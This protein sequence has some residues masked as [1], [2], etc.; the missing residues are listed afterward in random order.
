[1]GGSTSGLTIGSHEQKSETTVGKGSPNPDRMD[2]DDIEH[3]T[4]E[5]LE[6]MS[7]NFSDAGSDSE[8]DIEEEFSASNEKLKND[9][10]DSVH[11]YFKA[12]SNRVKTF[13]QLILEDIDDLET[14]C[15]EM[16]SPSQHADL[17]NV[18]GS[19]SDEDPLKLKERI[20]SEI[21]EELD[22]PCE[23]H[24]LNGDYDT[25]YETHKDSERQLMFEWRRLEERLRQEEEQRLAEL[26]AEREQSLKSDSEEKEK[27]RLRSEQ[28]KEE[29]RRAE[30]ANQSEYLEP[31]EG[32][33]EISQSL[34]LEMVKQQYRD[35]QR[36]LHCVFVDLEKAYDRVPR[37]ELW[38]CMRK[39]G[40][41]EKYVRVVQDMY[42]RSRTVV[43]C[44][45]GQTEEFKVEVGLHQ[46][47]ALSP[48]QF[49]IVMDQLS[50]EV[51]QE[52]PW[53]M[54]FA[55]DI[56][57]CS[58]SREQ[59]EENLERWRFALERRGMKVSRSKTEYMCV[60]ERE[61]SGTVRLQGEEVKKVQEFKYLGSTVQ[62][63]GE[64]GKEVEKRVQAG[65]NGW[66]K[67][68]G[69]LCDRKISARIKGK[70]YRTVVRAAMLYGLETVSLR[71]RQESE[72]E[73][74]I[75]RLEEQIAEERRVFEEVQQKERRKSEA[76]CTTAVTKI[77]AAFRGTLVRRWSKKELNKRRE[78]ERRRQEERIEREKMRGREERMKMEWEKE[79]RRMEEE[80][81]H[82]RD[83]AER[84]RA[85]YEKAKQQEHHRLERERK[86][87]EQR[88][89]E[90]EEAKRIE[91]E[92]KIKSKEKQKRMEQMR[93]EEEM[94]KV[95]EEKNKK[96]EK[97]KVIQDEIKR[98]ED[99]ESPEEIEERSV[100][101]ERRK[102]QEDKENKSKEREKSQRTVDELKRKDDE[103]LP[104][105]TE[106]KR[107]EEVMKK[108][109]E[110]EE[111]TRKEE[112]KEDERKRKDE[113]TQKGIGE[114][115]LEED[116]KRKEVEEAKK[117]E[118]E[119]K[120]KEEEKQKSMEIR[121][122]KEEKRR[123]EEE[124]KRKEVEEAKKIEDE[125][126]RKEEEKQKSMEIR[127]VKEE[128][129]KVQVE[130]E[131]ER[132]DVEEARRT[133]DERKRKEEE[134]Q[135]SIDEGRVE[136][137]NKKKEE[138]EE[139]RTEAEIKRNE[140]EEKQE[141]MKGKRVVEEI[142]LKQ[143]Q[144]EPEQILEQ[145]RKELKQKEREGEEIVMKT[146]DDGQNTEERNRNVIKENIKELAD[147]KNTKTDK[148]S[149]KT[150]KWGKD[151]KCIDNESQIC[152][153]QSVNMSKSVLAR[154]LSSR[155][156][157]DEQHSCFLVSTLSTH[158]SSITVSTSEEKSLTDTRHQPQ[159]AL[160]D[161]SSAGV[162]DRTEQKR[163]AWIMNCT[164]WSKL[165]MQNKRKGLGV[166]PRRRGRRRAS[167]QNLL[168]LPVDTILKPGPWSSVKQV[169]SVT[170]EDLSSCSL[171]TLSE[172]TRLQTLTLR[173]CGLQA[174]DGLNHCTELQHID[175]QENNITYVDCGGLAKLEV[176]LLGRNQLTSIHGLDDAVNLT[177]LQLSHNTISRISGLGS[178]KRVH[179]LTV[180]HNQLISTRGLGEAFTLLHLDCSYNHLS[181][182]EGLENCV[183]LNTLDLRGNNLTEMPVL[184]NH[185]LLRE[186]YL[187][188][189]SICSLHGLDSCWLPLLRCL[190]VPQNSI[191][192]LPLLV[193]LLSLKTLNVSQNCLS[194][195]RNICM[196][197]QGCTHLQ[198]LNIT[199]NPVQQ[200]NNWRSSVLAVNP[201]LIKLNGEQTGASGKLSADS[202]QL[203]S[204][205]ALCQAHQDQID[206]VL[207]RHCI[208]I[209]SAPSALQAQLLV[210]N[211]AAELFQLAEEQ[212]YAHEY[213]DSGACETTIQ[214]PV[215]SSQ[216]QELSN[217][218]LTQE[219]SHQEKTQN[220][221]E[222]KTQSWQAPHLP[223]FTHKYQPP[224]GD[225][226]AGCAGSC[227]NATEKFRD[228]QASEDRC[229]RYGVQA[230]RMD[231]RTVAVMV[232]QRRWREHRQRR[233]AS[234]LGP[235]AI[236]PAR[237]SPQRE[238]KSC[239]TKPECLNKDYAATVIQAVWRGYMLRKRLTRALMLAQ[240]SEGDEA[241]EEVDMDEFIFDEEALEKDWIPLHPDMSPSSVL[242]YS[243]Q[244]Q[245]PKPLLHLPELHKS[246]CVQPWKPRQAW[247]SS[248]KAPVSEQS[249]SPDTS[250]RMHS[251][252][253]TLGKC[254]F[255]ERSEKILEEWGISSGS[256]AHLMLKRAQRMKPRK[257][258][259]LKK[260]LEKDVPSPQRVTLAPSLK[261]RISFRD[262]PVQ[263]SGGWG[264]GK[265]R[266]KANKFT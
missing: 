108:V 188:D 2:A 180:D 172:C 259:N 27:M 48:F 17:L 22:P 196:S 159:C 37:E 41:A 31:V 110:N 150:T 106:E 144:N 162:P 205:Q 214:E 101:D 134:K 192:Q 200:E 3:V 178:L 69:V 201:S 262:N 98:K 208:E 195:L 114:R 53:T 25:E 245:L 9:L 211:H 177:V 151:E 248:D 244:L 57:I 235:P 30:A 191:T 80:E 119:R 68:S 181:H 250:T 226:N 66:R 198:E 60:N 190:S 167:G 84:R 99:V 230:S 74:L 36:E 96:D 42:E 97:A 91:D 266:S 222:H 118:D 14:M 212:R 136:E 189:N 55:D 263:L 132:K 1:M 175:L 142:R 186:L 170:L 154:T 187:D 90:K 228:T 56:V 29:L 171:S 33:G 67:V 184:K 16:F 138:E 258:K 131:K 104:E 34:T 102:V 23:T 71:K 217:W 182:V 72:L 51:R 165:S 149:E 88:R 123:L 45:V 122:V 112:E 76:R 7:V 65:W 100:E 236:V 252:A 163:L 229:S 255:S 251:P 220:P 107:M 120:R 116:I 213:G 185:V 28:F 137:E 218:D 155:T 166:P 193:D 197:L 70:V 111:K 160:D 146:N 153:S 50:E 18:L 254:Y 207:Q 179:R 139:K 199:D 130:E 82:H 152:L 77:Q 148:E 32:D 247:I 164:P 174:L 158:N 46:G 35:G 54:M 10:P 11:I 109:Q 260:Y 64:C 242:P 249:Q 237:L 257:Q 13:E 194:E 209:S 216:L 135:K 157:Q 4:E 203:W 78:E 204:F 62:S 20:M 115:R 233:R 231:L 124:R 81:Q 168:P 143:K 127:R 6:K 253:S 240:I 89:K 126:K 169:T 161:S 141:R 234:H 202:T 261:E 105:M 79:R 24:E 133:E 156:G 92:R 93:V 125:R 145:Q 103:E 12:S 40:V 43:R 39:S 210:G 21:E 61:G 26:E 256:T 121:R 183:L 19:N 246:A 15:N 232:I 265:K 221:A 113:K 227:V 5:E 140:E 85:K 219:T 215:A 44:A 38:Y 83:E 63:N 52:S 225:H 73:E 47:S 95:Q 128:K 173:R 8:T 59:V 129:W 206:S 224:S 243:E 223:N 238:V 239:T 264:G 176:L 147:R 241:F 58:E 94:R 86:L 75:K 87:E 117:I 49:A